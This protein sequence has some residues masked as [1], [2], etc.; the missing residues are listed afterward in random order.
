MARQRRRGPGW[1][2]ACLASFT[3]IVWTALASADTY[4]RQIGID[5]WHYVFRLELSD[6]QP[7]IT[8]EATVDLRITKDG[9]EQV[10]LDL[11]SAANGK[12]MTVTEVTSG[13]EAVPFVHRNNVLSLRL[14]PPYRADRHALFKIAYHGVPA[15]GL[16]LLTNKYGE[17]CAFSEN[18]PNR[19][20]EWLP[21]I[22]HPYD[23]ATSELIVTTAAKYQ[24]VANG[25]LQEETDLGDG[26]R[27]TH[28]KQSV[29]IASWLNAIGVQQFAVFHA[30]TVRGVELQTW[31][32]RQDAGTGRVYFEGPARQAMDF[33]SEHVGPYPYEK[34][35]NVAAAGINGGTEH[36][37]AIFYGERGVRGEPAT[38]LVAHEVA[39]QWFGDAVTESDWDDV[40]LSE[41]F[42]TYFTLLFTEHY[43][44]RDAFVRALEASRARAIATEKSLPGISVIHNNLS[45]MSKVLNQLVYQKGAW[46]LHMLRGVV[47]TETFWAGIRE[48]YRRY[49]DATATTADLR[50]VMEEASRRDLAWFFDQ[51]LLRAGSPSFRGGW[52]YNAAARQIEVEIEQTQPGDAYRM[53]FE[54]GIRNEDR[55]Q[56]TTRI[57][58]LEMKSK[59]SVFTIPAEREPAA[60]SFDPDRWLLMDQISFEKRQ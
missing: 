16:R 51:W 17:W 10:A 48:Y 38:S 53:P 40:W 29:P 20:R 19:A 45:D 59:Y 21:M 39:H 44:G 37:S 42:A 56:A 5:A 15:D 12:G 18:W 60:V 57:E 31:V 41:G 52:R 54:L 28:W 34:L 1:S 36:A 55:P 14:A 49:R 7:E 58:R 13:G 22:D 47:G 33:Y 23:K 3:L 24:V 46:V 8:G 27:R 25:L 6:T 32:A 4:P 2:P 50:H 35:A 9:V 26:R 43:A 11:A 30:G